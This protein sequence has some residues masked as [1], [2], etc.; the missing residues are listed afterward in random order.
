MK[1]ITHIPFNFDYNEFSKQTN[2]SRYADQSANLAA[3]LDKVVP[4]VKPKALYRV[5]YITGRRGTNIF[6][7]G[8]KFK[9]RVLSQNLKEVERVFPYIATCGTELDDI[10]LSEDDLLAR[11][12]LDTIKQMA[13][14]AAFEYVRLL[15]CRKFKINQLSTMNPGSGESELWPIGQQQP[16]F[17]LFGDYG[18]VESLI[19]VK[20]TKSFLMTPNKTVSGIFFQTETPFD[21]CRLCSREHCARRKVPYEGDTDNISHART[22]AA[23]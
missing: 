3:L 16:L 17:S 23:G 22:G 1:T 9:S 6:L 21:S 18:T 19:G 4:L 5:C 20:L 8:V 15:L 7:Q 11:F 14:T 13:L 2:L 12:W 10:P